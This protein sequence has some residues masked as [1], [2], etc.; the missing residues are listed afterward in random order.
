MRKCF[1][2][3]G[4]GA[5]YPGMGRDLWEKSKSVQEL[6]VLASDV[7]KIDLKGLLFEGSED[8]LAKTNRT[9]IAVTLINVAAS[10]YIE[11]QGIESDGYAGF[12][13]GEYAALHA[14]GVFGSSELFQIVQARGDLME[15]ASRSSDTPGGRSGMAAVIGLSPEKVTE[16]LG[17]QS[18]EV[19][20]ANFSSPKQ[21]VL[22]GTA[23]GLDSVQEMFE[24][25][26]ARRFIR[27][28]VSGPFHSPLI[29]SASSNFENILNKFVFSDPVKPVYANVTGLEIKS[30]NEARQ[31]C[32]EQ[33]SSSVQWVKE[34]NQLS[35]VGFSKFYET[36][37]GKVLT[38]L[39]RAF[40]L[41]VECFPAGTV[42][43]I[44]AAISKS[45]NQESN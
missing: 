33:I 43:N 13:I 38:G 45:H 44:E 11:E 14:S 34:I 17:N 22:A 12:S 15:L 5:Q 37:P 1:L 10:Y 16:I 31:L 23:E 40:D 4:Q 36:G 6:F 25:A 28:K 18:N 21:V 41:N 19:F 24:S 26:G 29:K 2:F 42:D 3:P 27:L 32:V 35:Q 9:Q 7:T 8:E 30:G 20:A 39:F